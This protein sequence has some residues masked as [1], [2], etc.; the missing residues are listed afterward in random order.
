MI[1]PA[2]LTSSDHKSGIIVTTCNSDVAGSIG[3]V[4]KLPLLSYKDSKRLFYRGT[5]FGT[6]GRCPSEYR[7][8]SDRILNKCAQLPLAIITISNLVSSGLPEIDEWRKVCNSIGTGLEIDDSL[9]DMRD[10]LSRSLEVLPV[11]LKPCLLYLGIFPEDYVIRKDSLVQRWISEGLI[12]E[13]HEQKTQNLQLQQKGESYFYQLLDMGMIQPIEFD[14]DGKALTCHVPVVILDLIMYL[15]K[16]EGVNNTSGGQLQTERLCM[17]VS[18]GQHFSEISE[19]NIPADT[20][21]QARSIFCSVESMTVLSTFQNLHVLLL[22]GLLDNRHI[23]K[24]IVGLPQLT[25]LSL[26]STGVT[27]IPKKIGKLRSLETLDLRGTSVKELPSTVVHLKKLRSLLV[28]RCTKVP[29]GIGK[30]QA[31]EEL[32]DIDICNSTDVLKDICSMPDLRVLRIALWSW[33][34][35]YSKRLAET[36]RKLSTE[37]L[38]EL[39]IFTCCLLD[40]RPDDIQP[41]LKKIE[42]IEIRG[43]TFNTLPN[44]IDKLRNLNSLSI[45]VYLLGEEALGI[46]G[47]LPDLEF[48]SLAAKKTS[49]GRVGGENLAVGSLGFDRLKTFLLF[50]RAIGIKFEKGSMRKLENL[51]LSFQASLMKKDQVWDFGLENLSSLKH[52]KVEIICFSATDEVVNKAEGA[53]RKMIAK[54]PIQPRPALNIKRTVKEYML[55]DENVLFGSSLAR[56]GTAAKPCKFS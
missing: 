46:L 43:S 29:A 50:S 22:E 23:S 38:K 17:Q 48:L 47:E 21:R 51:E 24:Y 9:K 45:E 11:N 4:Y 39:T 52:A 44:W 34:E 2:L 25:Y 20:P 13:K 35:S 27:E 32:A 26:L 56:F 54:N 18:N 14:S 41:A 37:K 33:D 28:N 8:V 49:Q 12:G 31:L 10:K 19:I 42:K 6:E 55:K 30:L 40:F 53:I 5:Y 7:E 16:K 3:G 15:L 36:L 1:K